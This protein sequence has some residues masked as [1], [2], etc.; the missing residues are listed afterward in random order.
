VKSWLKFLIPTAFTL[1]IGGIYLF[2]VWKQRQDPGVIAQNSAQKL[3][4]DDL[5]VVRQLFPAHFE[6]T[7]Q[8]QGTTVWMKNGYTISY[9]PATLSRIDFAHPAGVVPSVQRLEIKKILKSAVPAS[10][11]DGVSHGSQQVF[12]VF[13][14]PGQSGLFA[15]PIGVTD[16]VDEAYYCDVFFFYDDPHTIYDN[17]SKDTWAAIDAHQVKPGMSELQTRL[18]IGQNM[19]PDSSQQGNRTVTFDQASKHWTVTFVGN[20]ATTIQGM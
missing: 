14:L 6:D 4:A 3:S 5:A 20:H 1:L 18:A 19:H 13:A 10:L 15:L 8:L 16:G 17:W 11:D 7:L 2:T 12:A 9:F